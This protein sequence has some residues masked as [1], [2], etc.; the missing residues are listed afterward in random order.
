MKSYASDWWVKE[1]SIC[2]V[3]IRP[4]G[5]RCSLLVVVVK[6]LLVARE[7]LLIIEV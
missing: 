6:L 3:S 2:K 1:D 5:K 4:V 7:L